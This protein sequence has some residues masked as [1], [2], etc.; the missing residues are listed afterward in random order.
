MEVLLTP[1]QQAFVRQAILSGRIRHEQDAIMEAFA[2]WEERE[3]LRVEILAAVE[4]ADASLA[5]G[6]GR[7]VSRQSMTDL[8]ADVKRRGRA[9][10]ASGDSAL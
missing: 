6:E 4:E 10:V 5:A 1:D 8:A 9:R 7:V 3:R 2:L